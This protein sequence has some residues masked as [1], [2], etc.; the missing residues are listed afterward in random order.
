MKLLVLLVFGTSVFMS[1]ALERFSES[2]LQPHVF[3][4]ASNPQKPVSPTLTDYLRL[5]YLSLEESLWQLMESGTDNAFVLEQIHA[6]HLTFFKERFGEFNVPLD[7]PDPYERQLQNVIRAVN[8]TVTYLI[9]HCLQT[10][11]LEFDELEVITSA[12]RQFNFTTKLDLIHNVT[13]FT[14]FFQTIK[15]VSVFKF[16]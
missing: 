7:A 10:N 3:A 13:E 9:E 2:S 11:P 16:K 14:D 8:R 5:H 1:N 12:R 4:P 6:V 15:N